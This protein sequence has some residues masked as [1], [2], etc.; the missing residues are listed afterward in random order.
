MRTTYGVPGLSG[1]RDSFDASRDA[2]ERCELQVLMR[3]Q[4]ETN[5]ASFEPEFLEQE[6]GL[7]ATEGEFAAL[8]PEALHRSEPP[9]VELPPSLRQVH[10]PRGRWLR[11]LAAAGTTE[12][13]EFFDVMWRQPLEVRV[14]NGESM[15]GH[16]V[17]ESPRNQ[18]P[19]GPFVYP[20]EQVGVPRQEDAEVRRRAARHEVD[21]DVTPVFLRDADRQLVREVANG[22]L[23]AFPERQ[24]RVE[25][26]SIFLERIVEVGDLVALGPEPPVVWVRDDSIENHQPLDKPARGGGPPIAVVRLSDGLVQ[27]LVLHVKEAALMELS[28]RDRSGVSASDE[29]AQEVLRLLPVLDAHERPVLA[30]DEDA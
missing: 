3:D 21:E 14:P 7:K 6:V 18:D 13:V 25:E 10:S 20:Q 15:E 8:L 27:R 16:R 19:N 2:D 29:V 26:S 9:R 28:W 11:R 5:R 23:L 24:L 17:P 22:L 1:C 12:P 4:D 30:F